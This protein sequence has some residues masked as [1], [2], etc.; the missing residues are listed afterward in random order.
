MGLEQLRPTKRNILSQSKHLDLNRLQAEKG[1][2]FGVN[3][4]QETRQP[5][6]I[7]VPFGVSIAQVKPVGR[8]TSA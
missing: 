6:D 7:E 4:G 1:G 3:R 5:D 8:I 2:D